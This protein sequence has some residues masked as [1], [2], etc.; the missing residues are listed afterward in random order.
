MATL[1]RVD[2]NG[3]KYYSGLVTCERCGGAGGHDKWAYTGWTCYECGG[4]GK[5]QGTW[6]EYTEEY[7][8]K[9]DAK[10]QERAAKRQAKA[11]AEADEKRKEWLTRNQF[12]AN[13][14]TYSFI[15]NTYD[16]KDELKALG[17]KFDYILGWHINK[18]VDGYTMKA[19]NIN[20]I[21]TPNLYGYNIDAAKV[22]EKMAEGKEEQPAYNSEY[23]GN[24]GDKIDTTATLE[25]SAWFEV[26]SFAG[27][28]TDIMKVYTFRDAQGNA[29]VWKTTGKGLDLE[30]GAKVQIT[31][32]VKEHNEYKEEKQTVLTRCKIK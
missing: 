10:A 28:G 19:L 26:K 13:G 12:D 18:V 17:A 22:A 11:E 31:G 7:R 3:T 23:V 29:L 21:A 9:L 24:V 4:T 25:K 32:T 2:R 1:I 8:A 27:Y 14:N 16:I 30:D 5:V 15:G 20:D 6:K